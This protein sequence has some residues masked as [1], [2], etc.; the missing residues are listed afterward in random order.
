MEDGTTM[1]EN[2]N[3]AEI[4]LVA[5]NVRQGNHLW[6]T[7]HTSTDVQDV[8]RKARELRDDPEQR[9]HWIW[10]NFDI[11]DGNGDAVPH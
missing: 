1:D 2:K 10:W 9:H 6:T 5:R 4:R 3:A 7:L 8:I 11:V